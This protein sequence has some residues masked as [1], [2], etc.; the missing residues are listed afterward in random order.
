M[1][2]REFISRN[3]LKVE[4]YN[5]TTGE[6]TCR[7]PAHDDRTASLTVNVK[8]SRYNGAPRIVLCCHAG[9]TE[10]QILAALGLKVQDLRDDNTPPNG[11]AP[12]G[13]TVRQA[14]PTPPLKPEAAKPEK[15]PLKPLPPITKIYSYTDANGKEL[16]QVTRHDYIGDDGKHAKTFRQRMYAPENKNAKK[17]GFVWSVP[18]SIKLHTLY[19]LPEVNAAIRDGRTVYVVEGEKDAD[20]LA[21]LGHAATTQPQGAG[22]W[23]DSYSELLRGAHVV[24]LPDADTAENSYAGQE[25][26]WKVCTSLTH[27]AKS[28]KMVNL[29][30]CCPELPPKGDI[31]DMVEL[32]GERPAMDALA[33]Q[34]GE[35]LPFDPAGVKYWLSPSERAA[36]LFGKIPGYCAADGCICRVAADGGRK[37]ICDFVAIPHSEIM[38]DDG[39]NRNMAFEV[40]AWTQDGRQLPRTRVKASDFGGMSWVTSAWGLQ[41]NVMPG[42]S[43][44]DHARYAIAAV[45][46]MTAAHITEYSHTG[47]RKI[48]GKWCYLYHGGAVGADGVRV[49]LDGGLSGYRLDGAGAAGFDGISAEAA[50]AASWGIRN[51]IAPH[52]AIPLLGTIYLAPLWEFLNQTNVKPSYGLYLAGGTG[53]R[54][55]T[56]AALALSHFGNFTSKTL[57]AS[58]HDTGNTIRRRAFILKDMPFVVDDF[59]PTGSQQEKRQLKEIAQSLSRMAGDGAERGRMRPDGTL[60]PATPPRCVTIITGEDIPDVGESGLA[61]YYMVSIQPND[62]PI[63]A[64][65]TAAQETARNGYMQRAMLGYIEWLRAQADE[66]PETLH[67]RFLDMRTWATEKAKDQHARA[68]ETIA[69]ILTGY[70]MMLLYFRHVG[71]LDQDACTAAIA[72]A[73]ATLTATSK[74]QARIIKEDKPVNI[75]LDSVAELLA[76]KEVFVTDISASATEGGKPSAA[77]G[78]E[79]VGC[80][81]ESYYYLIPRIIYKCVQELCVKQGSTFPISLRSLYRDLRTADILRSGVNCTEERPTKSKRIGDNSIFYLWIP[82][83]KIDGV[84]D[85]GEK[86]MRVNFTQVETSDLPP[87]WI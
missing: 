23:A 34:I 41:A 84:H 9:C 10:A 71:L 11:G 13:M 82:R 4:H 72:E 1:D 39:V 61:R 77:V 75:F 80:R 29:K 14:V 53:S 68:P 87:E 2:I 44:K 12:R 57:P 79:L 3:N 52:V 43:A 40:D 36:Q 74:E 65:L 83:D 69:H 16:F 70:Y 59:H 8:P 6:Y 81:D 48:A 45:G 55:S 51:V 78:R 19:R 64:E 35:T 33:R 27:I 32:M 58:F 31:T 7:C 86:Q 25:H 56:S 22:K 85:E 24:M 20:T 42:N 67:K 26:G 47:W 54:K 62:V 63:S 66:L 46:K 60:Q 21:R 50:A 28:I 5:S 30:A 49:N 15:K 73:M 17:D 37:P 76:S 38:Q 18:D